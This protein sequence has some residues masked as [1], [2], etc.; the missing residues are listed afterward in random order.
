M[1]FETM[2]FILNELRWV[3]IKWPGRRRALERVRR[4]VGKGRGKFYWQCEQCHE[5]SRDIGSME[6]DHVIEVGELK[7]E[8]DLM[9]LI[10]RLFDESNLQVLCISCHRKKTAVFNSLRLGLK[11]K[12]RVPI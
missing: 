9:E 4:K 2:K 12:K 6:V 11:R 1:E 8:S 7:P 10:K 3:S 5:W